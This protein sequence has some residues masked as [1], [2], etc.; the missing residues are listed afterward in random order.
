[1]QSRPFFYQ[2]ENSFGNYLPAILGA[3][4]IFVGGLIIALLV[5]AGIRKAMHVLRVDERVNRETEARVSLANVAASIGFW[6]VMILA[7]LG[8][9]SILRIEGLSGP[10]ETLVSTIMLYLPRLLLAALLALLAWL[11]A[12]VLRA[13]V[14]RV[15]AMSGWDEKLSA[16]AGV[17]PLSS[18]LGNVVY[19]IV[20]LLFL[21]AIVGALQIEGLMGPLSAMTH[22]FVS[23]LPAVFAAV[24]IGV[25][26]WLIARVLRGLVTNL[27]AAA[28]VD[29]FDNRAGLSEGVRLSR[30]GG[31][32]VFILVIVPTLIAA[33]DALQIT[34]IS[35]PARD[36][37][38][39]FLAAV[40]NIIAAALIL[41]IAWF[42]GRF[43]AALVARL[44]EN[45]GF[46]RLPQRLGLGHAFGTASSGVIET[47]E[48]TPPSALASEQRTLDGIAP[49]PHAATLPPLSEFVG[50]LVLFFI[51]LFATV[52]A[53]YRLGFLGVH[54]LLET[55]IR[56]GAD[57]LLGAIILVVGYW[58]ANLAATA[59]QRANPGN[60]VGLARIARVAIL[61]LVLAMGLRAMGI[62][63]DIV[64][65]AFGLVLG[66]VAVAVA[67]AFG[68]GG[69]AAAGQVAQHWASRY[70]AGRD[71][72]PR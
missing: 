9:F 1:M 50:R 56:F 72:D 7:L 35:Q 49:A 34:A 19:W 52:E 45:L 44:L 15:M 61:G 28:G 66:A 17:K 43:V 8:M 58:L 30:L 26:G 14:N 47:P 13:A 16:S 3:V 10:F 6:L 59:I 69:R 31:T 42:V 2:L 48:A 54:E 55:F 24:V 68:L 37:L 70:L 27:L 4:A 53:A 22:Q 25:V 51:L 40:P 57:V 67:L 29:R 32:V 41:L 36:M 20:L 18:V 38:A 65:L 11:L 5:R 62:A 12:T 71:N 60:A 46:D 33:L 23:A 39:M 64:N 21:P 63:D